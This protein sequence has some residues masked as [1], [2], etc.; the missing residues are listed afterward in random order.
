MR[1]IK[2]QF[3][4]C[5]A[6][7][8]ITFHLIAEAVWAKEFRPMILIG[9]GNVGMDVLSFDGDQVLFGAIFAVSRDL[10]GPQFP[11][12]PDAEDASRAWV[13]CPSL[14]MASPTLRQ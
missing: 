11:P 9:R 14:P 13:G 5:W 10:P 6:E 12:G 1:P 3:F 4:A 7:I 2:T 8:D